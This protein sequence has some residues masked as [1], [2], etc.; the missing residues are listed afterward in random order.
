MLI[1]P[2]VDIRDGRCVRL[3]HGELQRETMYYENP[4][5]AALHWE[6]EGAQRL[7]VV[8]LDG[9]FDGSIKN[10]AVIEE[11][12]RAVQIPIQ[13]GGG[14][15]ESQVAADLLARGVSRV[16][17]GTAAVQQPQVVAELCARYPGQ[18]MVGIDA[19]AGRV[20]IRGWVEEAP[21]LAIDLA[22]QMAQLGVREIIYTDIL[23]DGTLKGP[24]VAALAE[25][26]QAVSLSVIASGGIASLQDILELTP[27]QPQGLSGIIVGQAL[28]T[29]R[30]SLPA[31]L[32]IT[33][34]L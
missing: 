29:G 22:Q 11:I 19:R 34:G 30:I 5:E 21:M 20:A 14:I 1:I 17:M 8:D 33:E 4:V 9:A 25:V 3:V 18:I 16:I 26:T 6:S 15:R 13:V 7:H 32:A 10:I 2:A 28:Y 12:V 31:A 27:L 23:R 24:N